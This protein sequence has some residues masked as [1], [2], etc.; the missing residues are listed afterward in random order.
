MK[1]SVGGVTLNRVLSPIFPRRRPCG[2]E[3]RRDLRRRSRELKAYLVET[4]T[5]TWSRAEARRTAA[6]SE[7]RLVCFMLEIAPR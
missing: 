3:H 4:R 7:L 5:Q 1:I 2:S 6:R